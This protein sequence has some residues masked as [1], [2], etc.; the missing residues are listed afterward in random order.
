MKSIESF[1]NP[2]F[3][4]TN[5][6]TVTPTGVECYFNEKYCAPT[7]C[8]LS[9]GRGKS[10]Y[11]STG[12][13]FIQPLASALISVEILRR[14]KEGTYTNMNLKVETSLCKLGDVKGANGIINNLMGLSMKSLSRLKCPLQGNVTITRMPLMIF[15]VQ[16]LLPDADYKLFAK[17]F[18]GVESILQLNLS[19][20]VTSAK[21]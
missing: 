8:F 10:K 16:G 7:Y 14:T 17:V 6:L 19:V 11:L 20:K 18:R 3:A 4:K 13:N 9:K 1:E 21:R 2:S 5:Y 15:L 12:C